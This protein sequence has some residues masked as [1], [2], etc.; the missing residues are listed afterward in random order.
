MRKNPHTRTVADKPPDHQGEEEEPR[1]LR[2]IG[3]FVAKS[4]K[5]ANGLVKKSIKAEGV[6]Y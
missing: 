4:S 1:H 3:Y 5:V 2:I 6:W